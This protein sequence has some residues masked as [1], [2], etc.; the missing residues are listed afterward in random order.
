MLYPIPN[1]T[2]PPIYGRDITPTERLSHLLYT[3]TVGYFYWGFCFSVAESNFANMHKNQR[4]LIHH[5]RHPGTPTSYV[6]TFQYSP[7]N[8]LTPID[9]QS[10]KLQMGIATFFSTAVAPLHQH[11]HRPRMF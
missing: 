10:P 4:F 5:G 11:Q 3:K 6:D 7:G 9:I 1:E 2:F 8:E